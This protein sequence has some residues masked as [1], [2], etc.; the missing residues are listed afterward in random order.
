MDSFTA[1][2]G[3][4][5]TMMWDR[6]VADERDLARYC[7]TVGAHRTMT[8]WLLSR[9]CTPVFLPSYN[10][11][12]KKKTEPAIYQVIRDRGQHVGAPRQRGMR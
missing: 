1:R 9:G 12:Q 2:P 5:C 11:I 4:T 8:S 10:A 6:L 7:Q 3:E